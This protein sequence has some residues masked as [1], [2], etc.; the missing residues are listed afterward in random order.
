MGNLKAK[1]RNFSCSLS[2]SLSVDLECD[3]IFLYSEVFRLLKSI[4]LTSTSSD[5]VSMEFIEFSELFLANP[6]GCWLKS[7][8]G[9]F[10]IVEKILLCSIMS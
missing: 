9:L 4:F 6:L 2:L 8:A 5:S 1:A 7:M 3:L 10:S